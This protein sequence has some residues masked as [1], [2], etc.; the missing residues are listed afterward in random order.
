MH[1]TSLIVESPRKP[2]LNPNKRKSLVM[3]HD[4]RYPDRPEKIMTKIKCLMLAFLL[5]LIGLG[6]LN[7]KPKSEINTQSIITPI[8]EVTELPPLIT[9]EKKKIIPMINTPWL[10]LTLICVFFSTATHAQNQTIAGIPYVIDADT[11][12]INNTRIRLE[13]IDAPESKQTC[14]QN[15]QTVAC[16]KAATLFV[17]DFLDNTHVACSVSSIDRYGRSI[18]TCY[19]DDININETIVAYGWALAYRRYSSA[20]INAENNAKAQNR[21]LWQMT[22]I[23]PWEWRRQ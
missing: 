23:P 6:W 22:F 15:T 9:F 3:A 10:I 13:G 11:L 5:S 19:A 12:D 20:Y 4:T 2:Y 1:S 18:A 14:T 17:Q 7:Q 16:G 8:I 21:G